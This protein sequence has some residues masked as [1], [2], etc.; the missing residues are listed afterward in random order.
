MSY[1]LIGLGKRRIEGGL[2]FRGVTN[3]EKIFWSDYDNEN[4]E[5]PDRQAPGGFYFTLEPFLFFSN[6]PS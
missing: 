5:V 6:S 3:H 4:L 1:E 2:L